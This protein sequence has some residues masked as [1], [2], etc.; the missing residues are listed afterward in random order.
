M[1][2]FSEQ[3]RLHIYC[4]LINTT[5]CVVI[6][7]TARNARIAVGTRIND[8]IKENVHDALDLLYHPD[9]NPI[10]LIRGDMENRVA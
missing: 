2:T 6:C 10:K 8:T 7:F 3:K 9:V 1:H 5:V 4:A